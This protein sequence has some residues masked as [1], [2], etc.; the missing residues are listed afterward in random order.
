MPASA[1]K[2]D[3]NAFLKFNANDQGQESVVPWLNDLQVKADRKAV[4]IYY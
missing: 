1:C 3:S 2:H 4:I